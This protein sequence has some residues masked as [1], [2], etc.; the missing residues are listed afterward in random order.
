MRH[1][2]LTVR[3]DLFGHDCSTFACGV[4]AFNVFHSLDDYNTLDR[5]KA[6]A[7]CSSGSRKH[8]ELQ[9]PDAEKILG[10]TFTGLSRRQR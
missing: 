9:L 10:T 8:C 6:H 7:R 4:A 3:L 1:A 5:D 2:L